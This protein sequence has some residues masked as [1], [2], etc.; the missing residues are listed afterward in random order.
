M[1]VIREVADG[2]DTATCPFGRRNCRPGESE[3]VDQVQRERTV[4]RSV[5]NADRG[6]SE[7]M[8]AD[9]LLNGLPL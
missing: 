3:K 2:I 9:R 8:L 6:H 5:A 1:E 7:P 4:R